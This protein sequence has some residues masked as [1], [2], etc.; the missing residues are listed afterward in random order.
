MQFTRAKQEYLSSITR[1]LQKNGLPA[2]DLLTSSVQLLLAVDNKQLAGCIGLE[3]FGTQGLLRSFAVAESYR[4]KGIGT[5]LWEKIAE[6]CKQLGVQK[7]HLLTTTAEDYFLKKGFQKADRA[8]AP[9]TIK[10]TY[11]FTT[12]CPASAAYLVLSF[13][14]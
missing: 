9:N 14:F 1:L 11:E 5:Q 10:N 12:A 3:Y 7:L 13:E 8:Q 2:D 6:F 4:N